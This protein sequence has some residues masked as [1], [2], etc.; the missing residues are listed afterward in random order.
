VGRTLHH[1]NH[2]IIV[3]GDPLPGRLASTRGIRP[4][5]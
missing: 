1:A 3:T 5:R 2:P 4:S